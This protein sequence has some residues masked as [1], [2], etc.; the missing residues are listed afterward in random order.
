MRWRGSADRADV[1]PADGARVDRAR[2]RAPRHHGVPS[3]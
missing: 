1:G 2:G 3:N